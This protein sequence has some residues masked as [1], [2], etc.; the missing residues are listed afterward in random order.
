[1]KFEDYF[2]IKGTYEFVDG[3]YNVKGF[4]DLIK[5]VE[6]LPV[7]FGIVTGNFYCTHNNLTSL[8][9][10]PTQV[11]GFF[12][13]YHNKLTSL[14]CAPTQVGGSFCC[15]NNSLTSLKG[16][17]KSVGG[18]FFCHNNNLTSLEGIPSS[19]CGNFICD[20][21]LHDT[22]EYKQYLIMKELRK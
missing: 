11:G 9:G 21:N 1:M 2:S 17:P 14:K 8:E 22:K 15:Y 3:V 12:Y 4:A 7:K 5:K 20:K 19:I 16:S 6:K 13:C 10:A 18:N